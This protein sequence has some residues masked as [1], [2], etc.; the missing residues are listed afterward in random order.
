MQDIDECQNDPCLNGATCTNTPGSYNCTCDT[1]WTGIV[2]DEGKEIENVL[3]HR[4]L[5]RKSMF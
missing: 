5:M 4:F 3:R 2:C 1:G